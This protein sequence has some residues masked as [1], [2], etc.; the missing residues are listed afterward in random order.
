MA[1]TTNTARDNNLIP[2]LSSLVIC[3]LVITGLIASGILVPKS[4]TPSVADK[5]QSEHLTTKPL[6]PTFT[7]HMQQGDSYAAKNMTS[8]AYNEYIA[9]NQLDSTQKDPYVRI[10]NLHIQNREY[11]KAQEIFQ[12]LLQKN[13]DDL[14]ANIALSKIYIAQ[15]NPAKA[16]EI[17][18]TIPGNPPEKSYYLG[19]IAISATQYDEG[20]KLLT[21][22]ISQASAASPS[23]STSSASHFQG[24]AQKILNAFNEYAQYDGSHEIFLKTILAKNLTQ[25]HEP[26]LAIPLLFAILKE[27]K[28]YRDAWIVLGYAYL[29]IEDYA[30]SI[31][32][33]EEARKLDN[34]KPETLFF[35]GLAYDGAGNTQKAITLIE[36]AIQKGFE[37][38][39][40][41]AQRLA[42]MYLSIKDYEKAAKKYEEAIDINDTDISYYVRPMWL[43][44][45]KLN[46]PGHALLLAQ[47]A[48]KNHPNDAMALNLVGWS[49]IAIGDLESARTWLAKSLELDPNLAATHLNLGKLYEKNNSP[50]VAKRYYLSAFDLGKGTSVGDSAAEG[51]NKIIARTPPS[52]PIISPPISQQTKSQQMQANVL[53]PTLTPLQETR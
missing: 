23:P 46:E 49:Y 37:P 16:K 32:A 44:I 30:D 13:P 19:L 42:E 48:L 17:L 50:E 15:R 7:Q 10:G 52:Q 33:L 34:S 47:K 5:N 20:K 28:D 6:P 43:Y 12:Q 9:A 22:V 31:P 2:I 39:I 29:D 25:I 53:A 51:Y 26:T 35:L 1:N 14:E 36:A 41:A 45:D 4:S 21:A 24:N 3:G 8:L 18:N 40:Q 38:K 27:K 11:D